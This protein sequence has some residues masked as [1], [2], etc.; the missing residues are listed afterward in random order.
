MR[1]L[2]LWW[3][4][5]RPKTLLLS[6][7]PV[8]VGNGL[9]TQ[10]QFSLTVLTLSLT[11]AVLLQLL[12]NIANDYG[13]T[14]SG[15]DANRPGAPR[16]LQSGAISLQQARRALYLLIVLCLVSGS[17]LILLSSLF[18]HSKLL[19]FILGSISV[20]AATCYTLGSRPYG[21]RGLGDI[22]V[23]LFFGLAAVAGSYYLQS[24]QLP[25]WIWLPAAAVGLLSVGVL[26]INNIRDMQLDLAAGKRTVA[27]Y[28]GK[29]VALTYFSS[30]WVIAMALTASFA[31]LT[32]YCWVLICLIL[33]PFFLKLDR[34]LRL[35]SEFTNYN[36]CLVDMVKLTFTYEL[37]F[38]TGSVLS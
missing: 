23:F 4:A 11:T 9:A 30:S 15:V 22:S 33:I 17:L 34:R 38:F 21:Y 27:L 18:W 29:T 19:F 3:N 1:L 10:Q 16:Q 7:G 36:Q 37:L 20:I 8:L 32:P 6:I 28:L 5:A 24:Q 2:K 14:K 31:L 35:T 12:T 13:D 25:F 26:N